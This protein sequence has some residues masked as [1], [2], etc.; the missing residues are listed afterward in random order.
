MQLCTRPLVLV[1]ALQAAL[2]QMMHARAP[3]MR[4]AP[5][6]EQGGLVEEEDRGGRLCC[7]AVAVV[8]VYWVALL[9]LPAGSLGYNSLHSTKAEMV[10]Q[11]SQD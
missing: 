7:E 2:L 3:T 4:G 5:R 10:K 9:A 11:A 1:L 8:A 6:Q